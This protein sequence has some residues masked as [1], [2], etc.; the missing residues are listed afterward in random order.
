METNTNL[1]WFIKVVIIGGG[2]GT[3]IASN[4]PK[5]IIPIAGEPV[6]EYQIELVKRYSY[7]DILL[8]V[9]YLGNQIEKYLG[10]VINGV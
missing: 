5:S 4:V 8:I 6:V 9:G 1:N 10:M 7:T 2:K 3:R